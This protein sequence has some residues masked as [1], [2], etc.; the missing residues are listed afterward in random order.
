MILAI[1]TL[2]LISI[3]CLLLAWKPQCDT[4]LLPIILVTAWIAGIVLL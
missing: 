4:A 3:Y 1:Y 2:A